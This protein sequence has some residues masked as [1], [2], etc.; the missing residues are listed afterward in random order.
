MQRMIHVYKGNILLTEIPATA[1]R[2]MREIFS[3]SEDEKYIRYIDPLKKEAIEQ[4]QKKAIEKMAVMR[5]E[6]EN[7]EIKLLKQQ[8]SE[9]KALVEKVTQA[10][11]GAKTIKA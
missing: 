6:A 5:K 2:T 9:M 10:Q 8:L 4:E 1:E 7:E 3:G 11:T